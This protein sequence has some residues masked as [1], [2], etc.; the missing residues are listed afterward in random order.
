VLASYAPDVKN[1]ASDTPR[2]DLVALDPTTGARRTLLAG[3]AASLVEP[4][5]GFKRA[6]RLL[7]RNQPQLVFGG[8]HEDGVD[9]H[10]TLHFPDLPMLA[11][12]LD[13]NL[14][15]GRNVEAM[16][17][18]A[19]L[20]VYESVPPPDANAT[21]T[22]TEQVYVERKPL[23]SAPLAEDGSLRVE[24]PARKPLILELVD[25]DGKPVLTMREE[26]QVGPGEVITP[27]VPRRLFNGVCGGCHGSVSGHEGDVAVT[28]DALTGAS[29]SLSR[30][31]TAVK[32]Q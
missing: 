23:G 26:H 19:A 7:F 3:G 5:V 10:A 30:D 25:A 17:K 27:G 24:L 16:G 13:A 14:R 21:R 4:T 22:G 12:L 11:T 6:E 15:R 1:P 29:V 20:K 2:Y 32:L 9:D 28:P 31:R 18:A 8:H